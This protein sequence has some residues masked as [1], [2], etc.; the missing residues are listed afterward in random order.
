MHPSYESA[1]YV[2]APA[3]SAH[4]TS[5]PLAPGPR[6]PI[7]GSPRLE[8][9][10]G[11]LRRRLKRLRELVLPGAF[12]TPLGHRGPSF[13]SP[14]QRRALGAHRAP[15]RPHDQ[16]AARPAPA[17][18]SPGASARR[19]A[20]GPRRVVRATGRGGA[21]CEGSDRSGRW[22]RKVGRPTS[23]RQIATL[24]KGALCADPSRRSA[25]PRA[26]APAPRPLAVQARAG[27]DASG[28]DAIFLVG[29]SLPRSI[30]AADFSCS[31]RTP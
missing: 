20:L 2:A 1:A 21:C 8:A 13:S 9:A 23:T 5:P 10:R 27:A 11:R 18:S 19:R 28:A 24:R 31:R 12:Q 17:D 25:A 3:D 15:R 4:A 6:R 29:I 30:G 22:G 14:G 26:G 16:L 7:G